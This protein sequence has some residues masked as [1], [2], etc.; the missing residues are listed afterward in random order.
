MPSLLVTVRRSPELEAAV[1]R[2]LPRVP[3]AYLGTEQ[4]I[5]DPASVRALLVG[6]L[7]RELP[8]LR[9][10]SFPNLRLVQSVFSG[11][12]TVPFERLGADVKVAGNVGAYAP[13][14]AEHAVAL[15]LAVAKRIPS[16]QEEM[17]AGRLRPIA[18][19]LQ[20]SGGRAIV[21][22]LGAVG[23]EVARRLSGLGMSVEAVTRD[24]A[25]REGAGRTYPPAEFP[26]AAHGARLIV[27]CLPLT[28]AT[29]GWVGKAAFDAL[30]A[31]AIY[32]NV[33]RAETTDPEAL[34]LWLDAEPTSGAGIDVWWEEQFETGTV[35]L[36]FPLDGRPNLVASPHRAGHVA[37]A[38]AA[39]YEAALTNLSAYFGGRPVR[40]VVDRSEYPG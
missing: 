21:L 6:S 18:W 25:P 2:H 9:P 20:L 7:E 35:R 39:G 3:V 16:G 37:E 15:A 17:R 26:V 1:G 30:G 38:V 33:G 4:T 27:N 34:R 23:R 12:D 19:S 29:R 28:R 13:F 40:G 22:G 5:S 31:G 32:V 14:V 8:S 24:G 11:V 36:P 10:E